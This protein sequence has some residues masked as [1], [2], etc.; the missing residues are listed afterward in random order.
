MVETVEDAGKDE[1][2]EIIGREEQ[3]GNP[4]DSIAVNLLQASELV[5]DPPR[6]EGD[7]LA[8]EAD[9]TN[10]TTDNTAG[11]RERGGGKIR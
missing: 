2:A 3:G 1:G 7:T 8:G 9:S 10:D 11:G 5:A 4:I 6:E